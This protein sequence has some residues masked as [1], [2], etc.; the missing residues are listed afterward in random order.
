MTA[1]Q[2]T[3][4]P[5]S[6]APMPVVYPSCLYPSWWAGAS[7]IVIVTNHGSTPAIDVGDVEIFPWGVSFVAPPESGDDSALYSWPE[8]QN[9][10][11]AS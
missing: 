6:P 2:N 8:V 7:T 4:N 1:Q 9:L 3:P 10:H 11:M 5:S